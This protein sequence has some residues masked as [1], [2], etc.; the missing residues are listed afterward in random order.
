MATNW[1]ARGLP[2]ASVRGGLT[3]SGLFDLP[4]LVHTPM[5]I[6]LGLDETEARR[7][8]PMFFPSPGLPFHAVVGGAEGSEF[9]RQS[10]QMADF[11]GGTWESVPEKHHFSVVAPLAARGSAMIAKALELMRR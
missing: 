5:N 8:S 3:I 2:A 4:P 11:W 9:E 1:G 10:R 7:L 6:K